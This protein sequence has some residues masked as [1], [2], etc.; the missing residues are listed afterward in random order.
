MSII[1]KI[2][3]KTELSV[4]T[5]SNSAERNTHNKKLPKINETD[6]VKIE[7]ILKEWS[8]GFEILFPNN[9]IFLDLLKKNIL[10][11][12][13]KINDI[14]ANCLNNISKENN[15]EINQIKIEDIILTFILLE[16]TIELKCLVNKMDNYFEPVE[17]DRLN[18]L[19]SVDHVFKYIKEME[20]VTRLDD[21]FGVDPSQIS[22]WK[23]GKKK[24]TINS[25]LKIKN[26]MFGEHPDLGLIEI[27]EKKANTYCFLIYCGIVMENL[28]EET[29]YKNNQGIELLI[30][31]LHTYSEPIKNFFDKLVEK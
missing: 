13:K 20:N 24:F 7:E 6:I 8:K 5:G 22:N 16:F 27:K 21:I 14:R 2:D 10:K 28:L 17:T 29:K 9:K 26:N 11:L 1:K 30:A 12:I 25:L 4:F 3:K 23:K 19:L 18:N 31:F 15:F